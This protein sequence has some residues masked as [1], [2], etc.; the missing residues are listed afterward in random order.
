MGDNS[1]NKLKLT[2]TFTL[3]QPLRSA[4]LLME[5]NMAYTIN[6]L[7]KLSGVSTRTLR[8]YDETGLLKPA[9]VSDNQYR[10]Y[11]KEQALLLQQILFYRELDFS[12]HDIRQVLSSDT[13][14]KILSMRSQKLMLK[15]KLQR[16]KSMLRTIDSTMLHLSGE[17]SMQIDEFFDPIKLQ[18]TNLQKK[19]E[20]YFVSKGVLTTKEMKASW[21][22]LTHW[23]QADWNN[24]KGDGGNF[25]RKM[26]EAINLELKPQDEQVQTL[27]HQH[28]LM[29][30][31]LWSFN[32][33]SYLSLA[34]AYQDDKNFQQFCELH[35]IALHL[36]LV[37]AMK[38]YACHQLANE[39]QR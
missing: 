6:Q 20:H 14:D 21:E 16:I 23:T 8:F 34:R 4:C 12:L 26:A 35:H 29:I 9:Y 22:N 38:I 27:V 32:E 18:D 5:N 3:R 28:Y 15:E 25:Y 1:S 39:E 11:E 36:F 10:Y 2:L 17:L 37:E 30:K 13:F 7:A 33:A 31:P 19:Y 24:F